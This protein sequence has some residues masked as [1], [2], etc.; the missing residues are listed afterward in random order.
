MDVNKMS[1]HEHAG[2]F[3]KTDNMECLVVISPLRYV[4]S[5][6]LHRVFQRGMFGGGVLIRGLSGTSALI[7]NLKLKLLKV[8]TR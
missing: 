6:E 1:L 3:Q 4:P 2:F 8:F 5:L 7:A